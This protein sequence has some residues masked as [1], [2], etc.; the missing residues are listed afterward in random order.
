MEKFEEDLE[1]LVQRL[2]GNENGAV[3]KEMR[4]LKER[5]ISLHQKNLVKIN[6]SVMEL[7]CA[8]YLLL[9]GYNVSLERSL[10]SLSCDVYATK[11]LGTLIVEVETGFVP[12]EHALDPTTYCKARIASKITRYSGYAEKFVLATPP[13]YVMQIHPVLIKPPRDRQMGEIKEIKAL[14]DLHYSNPPVSLDEI[15]NARIHAVYILDVDEGTVKETDPIT[16][17]EKAQPILY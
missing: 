7:V 2:C 16:Y 13:H 10:D 4:I 8:K 3:S 11:G 6:H 17:V 9:S 14:C 12:P 15:K 1:F 5:L